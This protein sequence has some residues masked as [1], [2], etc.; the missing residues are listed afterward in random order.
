MIVTGCVFGN[1]TR[2]AKSFLGVKIDNLYKSTLDVTIQ[3]L[4]TMQCFRYGVLE[5]PIVG[6][7]LILPPYHSGLIG[8]QAV[9]KPGVH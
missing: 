6:Y 3:L 4:F 5:S 8:G 7:R 9:R 2:S 1:H